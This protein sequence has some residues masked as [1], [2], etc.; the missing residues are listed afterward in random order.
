MWHCPKIV[1]LCSA[2]NVVEAYAVA[3]ALEAGGIRASVVGDALQGAAGGLPLGETTAPRLWVSAE[4]L[5]RAREVLA[6]YRNRNT[7][8][9][10][11]DQGKSPTDEIDEDYDAWMQETGAVEEPPDDDRPRRDVSLLSVL[12][13][14]IGMGSIMAGVYYGLKND[15]L[16]TRYSARA[17][18][19]AVKIEQS[20]R[21]YPNVITT[22]PDMR[23]HWSGYSYAPEWIADHCYTVGGVRYSAGVTGNAKRERSV[24]IRY[25]PKDPGDCRMDDILPPS[26]CVSAG[27][28][29]A[30]F[31][32]FLAY[33]FR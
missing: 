21:Q 25:D 14:M 5:P 19:T 7:P 27:L 32:F 11:G 4:D 26:W 23:E 29:S 24:T 13:A 16:L 9:V 22:V 30:A 15:R 12:L 2:A 1:E 17:V 28:L 10:Q 3:D 8:D 6:E 18:A 31:L 20:V 33:Q